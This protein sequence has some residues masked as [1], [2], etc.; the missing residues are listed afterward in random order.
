MPAAQRADNNY[1][2]YTAAHAERLAFIRHCRNLDMTLDEM[3]T[4]LR[5]RD[6]P[7]AGLRRGQRAARRAH[8]PRRATHPRTARAGEGSEGA[9]RA[10]RCAACRSTTAASSRSSTPP[11]P[12][13]PR[14]QPIGTYVD[15][16]DQIRRSRSRLRPLY[17]SVLVGDSDVC[18]WPSGADR[19]SPTNGR[20]TPGR[21]PSGSD[22]GA[23]RPR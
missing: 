19:F 9:A 16:I 4:L 14:Q 7:V 11:P 18:S 21:R 12:R 3:R 8:R 1:R 2:V 23:V 10:L 6:A 5:L 13:A 15:R 17:F 20:C 22:G